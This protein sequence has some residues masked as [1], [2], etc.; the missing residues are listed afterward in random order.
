MPTAIDEKPLA[1]FIKWQ[2]FKQKLAVKLQKKSELLSTQT[3]KYMLIVFC[4]LFGGRSVAIIINTV[5]N[6][7]SAVKLAKISKPEH[8]NEDGQS[9][10]QPDSIITKKE[11][12]RVM[13]FENYML[14][15]KN[16]SVGRKQFDSII[17]SRPHLL[18]SIALFEKMYLSQNKK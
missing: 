2:A 16:D 12:D 4:I 9:I 15:L 5:T 1:I 11:Y 18:D 6:K 8:A 17:K 7:V 14:A 13:Q 10:L 3:K